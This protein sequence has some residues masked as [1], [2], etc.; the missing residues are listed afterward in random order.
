MQKWQMHVFVIIWKEKN[1]SKPKT[2]ILWLE[3]SESWRGRERALGCVE[4]TQVSQTYTRGRVAP[5]SRVH[6]LEERALV[7][8]RE[9]VH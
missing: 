7:K 2:E 5:N 6:H 9:K 3:R 4:I 1:T 8:E